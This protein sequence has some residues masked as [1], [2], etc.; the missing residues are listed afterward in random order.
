MYGT[1]DPVEIIID[2]KE[3]SERLGMPRDEGYEF[4]EKYISQLKEVCTP[5][6]CVL[7]TSVAIDGKDG[8]FFDFAD[9]HSKSLAKNLKNS[10][11]AFVIA[12]TLGVGA[13][14]LIQRLSAVSKADGFIADSV[15]S[16]MAEATIDLV[17][18][19]LG[20]TYSLC[21]RF[22][23]GYGDFD[24]SCQRDIL[25]ALNADRLLGIKLGDNFLMTPRKSIT[26]ICGVKEEKGI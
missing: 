13:D 18:S 2:K 24:I 12:V 20:K 26:A 15:A 10:Q 11:S 3:L 5:S 23:P 19:K 16:A 7:K 14:R 4:C 8:I 9:F 21:P 25:D 6:F 17:C 1:I 22:S